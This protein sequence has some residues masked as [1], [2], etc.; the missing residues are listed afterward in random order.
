MKIYVLADNHA[1]RNFDAEWGLSFFIEVEGKTILFDYGNTDL[2]LKNSI[3]LGLDIFN[4]DYFVLSHGHWDHGNGLKYLPRCKLICHPG[5]FIKR[6]RGSTYLGLP[7][8]FEEADEKFE[9]DMHSEPY[10]FAENIF[11]MGTIPRVTSFESKGT[12]QVLENGQLDL[13]VDDTG[14]AIKTSKGLVVISGCAHA[15]ICNT[16]EHAKEITGEDNVYAVLGGFHLKGGDAL[17]ELTIDYLKK[18]NIEFISTSHCTRFPALVQFANAFGSSPFETGQ[19][20][21]F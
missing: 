14:I 17:T 1:L 3:K 13:V 10:E 21:E 8:T 7:Y 9:L 6:Y 18:E 16:I 4:A 5:S 12:D 2:Y 15:G 11:F 19:I 20:L